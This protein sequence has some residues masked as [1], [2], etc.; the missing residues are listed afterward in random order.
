MLKFIVYFFFFQAEDGIRDGHVTGVQTCALPIFHVAVEAAE[1]GGSEVGDPRVVTTV[2]QAPTL[3]VE[4]LDER[5][6]IC[7]AARLRAR[8][9]CVHGGDHL[10]R[11]CLLPPGGRPRTYASVGYGTVTCAC[12]RA[13]EPR[14]ASCRGCVRSGS[15]VCSPPVTEFFTGSAT[16]GARRRCASSRLSRRTRR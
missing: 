6:G 3:R 4:E 8:C 14:G 2:V 1:L 10:H 12:R 13:T 11:S 15:P 16:S 7:R 9:Q 5:V